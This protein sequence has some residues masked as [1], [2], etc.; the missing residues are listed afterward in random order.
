MVNKKRVEIF[1]VELRTAC[2]SYFFAQNFNVEKLHNLTDKKCACTEL[3][4]EK[5]DIYKGLEL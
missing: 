1:L 5:F 3:M 4:N 2:Y